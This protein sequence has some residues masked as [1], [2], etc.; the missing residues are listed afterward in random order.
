MD[1]TL[2]SLYFNEPVNFLTIKK[3]R[4]S[5]IISSVDANMEQHGFL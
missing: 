3:N 4:K 2:S 1:L 5:V